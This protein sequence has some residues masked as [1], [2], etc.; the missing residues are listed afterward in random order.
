MEVGKPGRDVARFWA[1]KSSKLFLQAT[2][3]TSAKQLLSESS[4]DKGCTFP[5]FGDR[6]APQ[7]PFSSNPCCPIRLQHSECRN[8]LSAK[9][10]HIC[11]GEGEKDV[12]RGRH[13]YLGNL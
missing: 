2:G 12:G 13:W 9:G 4:E 5:D 7:S 3:L 10:S 8:D 1:V 11:H 6:S